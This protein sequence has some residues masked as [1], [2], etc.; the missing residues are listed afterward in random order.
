MSTSNTIADIENYST[1]PTL[2]N[3]NKIKLFMKDLIKAVG[4]T[5]QTVDTK[6]IDRAVSILRQK[7]KVMPS[8]SQMRYVYEQFYDTIPINHNLG[9]YMIKK[10]VRSR[11]GVLVSTIV[12]KPDVFSCP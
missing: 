3:E 9:R 7:Y 2:I 1:K 10:A 8:K 4:S 11:S 12:L 5:T 6:Q